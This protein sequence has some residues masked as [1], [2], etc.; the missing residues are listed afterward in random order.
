MSLVDQ[1]LLDIVVQTFPEASGTQLSLDIPPRRELGD[2]A[3][4]V[5]SLAK[6]THLAPP[7]IAE[8]LAGAIRNWSD[9]FHNVTI[10]GGYVNFC[11]T[12]HAWTELLSDLSTEDKPTRNETIVVDYIGANVGKPLH[13]GHLCTPSIGQSLINTYRFLGYNVIWDNHWWDWGGIFGKLIAA[14]KLFWN[15]QELEKSP[16]EYL[17]KL[18]IDITAKSEEDE[19]IAQRCRD[20]F[21]KLS[22]WDPTSVELWKEFVSYSIQAVNTINKTIN[23]QS[24]YNIWESFY[25][26]LYLPRLENNPPLQYSMKDIISELLKEW[27]ATKNE[28]GSVWI[29]FPEDSK[30]PSSVLQKKDWTSLYLTSDL[31]AIKYRLTNGWNPVKIIYCTD[32][33]QQLHF[34][35]LF[36]VAKSVWSDILNSRELIHAYN[37]FI[38]LKEGAMSTRKGIIIRFQDLIDEGYK[39]TDEILK[40]KW[41][42]LS[43]EDIKAV[44]IAAIKYSYLSV[45][46]EKDVVFDWDKALNFEGNSGPYIQYAYVRAKN[47]IEKAGKYNMSIQDDL[48]LS[49]Y[50]TSCLRKLTF[51]EKAVVDT[52]A[53]YKPHILATYCYELAS[54]FSSWY[55]H[56]PKVLEEPDIELRNFRLA[57]VERVR[58]TLK[59]GFE[60]LAIEMPGKM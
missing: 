58:D 23:V 22:E 56:T 48:N 37:W 45:D 47:I 11:L 3:L 10:L 19:E 21:K 50:D 17:L 7:A 15:K 46:R 52:A 9:Y 32:M 40:S 6:I 38:R 5:F 39:R 55:A 14:Y 12:P 20:E 25:E 36:W 4:G 18:Y 49:I 26:W 53:K 2:F 31:A 57:L 54:E 30:L 60:L 16:I 42:D 33:R 29:I 51:F 13:I 28:D 35:Q 41:A 1:L 34:R 27:I 44:T 24:D 43:Q 8:R 59:K